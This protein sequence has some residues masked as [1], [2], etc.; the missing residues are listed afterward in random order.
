MPQ[1]HLKD[2]D[3]IVTSLALLSGVWGAI[4]SFAKR[5]IENVTILR[6]AF[7]FLTDMFVNIGITML[8]YLGM[9][10]YGIDD[11][12]AVAAAGFVG[13]QGTRSFYLIELIITEKLGAKKTYEMLKEKEE[14]IK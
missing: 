10:G 9:I 3:D 13:H 8:V 2:M 11:L 7:I 14:K 12:L 6:K 4:I 1:K 5:D